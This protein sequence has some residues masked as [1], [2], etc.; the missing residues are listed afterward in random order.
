MGAKM[1][2]ATVGTSFV[3]EW[4][5]QACQ[6]EGSFEV[7]TVF[8]RS[9]ERGRVFA[10]KMG[11]KLVQSDWKALLN[12]PLIDVLYIATP[13]DTHFA[14][15]SEALNAKKHVILEK[16]QVSNSKELEALL[17]TAKANDRY[18]FDAIIPIHL[19]N[20]KVIKDNLD[21]VGN[22]KLVHSTFG[23]CS[24]RYA[25]LLAGEEPAIF[26]LKNSGGALMDLG[27]YPISLF[28]GLFGAPDKV[29][30]QCTKYTNGIDLNGVITLTY[31][32][33]LAVGVIAKASDGL[34]FTTF[35]GDKAW[36]K[37]SEAPSQLTEVVLIE[38]DKTTVL[39]TAQDKQTMVYE[40][41]DFHEVIANHDD[42]RYNDYTT[43]TRQ[44]FDV[45]D[46]CRR[47]TGLVFP[48]DG[49]Q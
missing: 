34:A 15:A 49:E 32:D 28:I 31:P 13:N 37:A 41:K 7:T 1:R 3:T 12:D 14:L 10:D 30:Y 22:L 36:I 44:V 23:K 47:Q 46:E 5:I 24:S 42:K 26:S 21:K 18:V 27:V 25:A 17:K 9:A 11:V 8:S 39:N 20:L 2:L 43:V 38:K 4:F 16:P 29:F 6:K 40:I 33:F 48:A 45:M 35:S 19:P